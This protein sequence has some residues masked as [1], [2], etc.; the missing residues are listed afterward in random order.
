MSTTQRLTKDL[1][2]HETVIK[3]IWKYS[4]LDQKIQPLKLQ[5]L[6]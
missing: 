2:T 1:L 4:I 5:A 6:Q 3:A